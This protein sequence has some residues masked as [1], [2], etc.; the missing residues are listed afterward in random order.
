VI[1]REWVAVGRG[2]VALWAELVFPVLM[3]FGVAWVTGMI[4]VGLLR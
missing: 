1:R 4:A 3:F 2:L